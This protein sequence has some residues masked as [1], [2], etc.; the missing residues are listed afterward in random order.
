MARHL[1][2]ELHLVHAAESPFNEEVID[3]LLGPYTQVQEELQQRIQWRLNEAVTDMDRQ[4]VEVHTDVWPGV[5]GEVLTAYA[6]KHRAN[7]IVV[8]V[9]QVGLVKKALIGS[10]T[11]TVLRHAPCAVL[12]VPFVNGNPQPKA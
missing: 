8:G 7:L 2:A 5:P 10:T 1:Q 6:T 4:A 12:T 3:P 11:E 9:R